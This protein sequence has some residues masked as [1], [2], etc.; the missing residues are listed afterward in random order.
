MLTLFP[1]RL[2]PALLVL[3]G[4]GLA[5]CGTRPVQPASPSPAPSGAPPAVKSDAERQAEFDRSMTRW[6]GAQV[7]EL[8]AKLGAPTSRTRLGNGEWIYSYSR[9]STVRGPAGPE[10]FSCVVNYRVDARREKVVGH[11]IQGC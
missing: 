1:S 10:R 11:R 7:K 8:V 6:H 2:L 4:A 5:G 9:S 3:I